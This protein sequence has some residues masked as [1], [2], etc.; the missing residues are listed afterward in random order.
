MSTATVNPTLESHPSQAVS[1]DTRL[2]RAC[3]TEI[4]NFAQDDQ[5]VGAQLWVCTECG[6]VRQWGFARPWDPLLR[7]LLHCHACWEPTRHAFVGLAGMR[8]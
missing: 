4:R 6:K 8:N 7:A 2:C 1:H 3:T 5:E